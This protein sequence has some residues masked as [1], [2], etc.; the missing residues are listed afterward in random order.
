MADL[1]L[2]SSEVIQIIR[3]GYSWSWH[4]MA[5]VG[6]TYSMYDPS[7]LQFQGRCFPSLLEQLPL[8]GRGSLHSI[9]LESWV[10][11]QSLSVFK[12]NSII[13]SFLQA[14]YLHV[15]CRDDMAQK[16][17]CAHMTFKS[18]F[19]LFSLEKRS[20]CE[21]RMVS[22]SNLIPAAFESSKLLRCWLKDPVS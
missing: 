14:S 13:C 2:T 8:T 15:A 6:Q 17:S 21:E 4:I 1:E 16:K 7:W 19:W 3:N 20:N 10:A 22:T 18:F 5:I 12:S 9:P 11:N